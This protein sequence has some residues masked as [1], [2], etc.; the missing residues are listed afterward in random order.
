M[1]NADKVWTRVQIC[2]EQLTF[3]VFVQFLCWLKTYIPRRTIF[4]TICV[5]FEAEKTTKIQICAMN[6]NLITL[7]FVG[8]STRNSWYCGKPV[9]VLSERSN[10]PLKTDFAVLR[11]LF[12]NENIGFL[13]S[14][15]WAQ[16]L[17]QI[18]NLK[19]VLLIFGIGL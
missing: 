17:L 5:N 8:S 1:P 11:Q 12:T 18:R 9:R 4:R 13:C 19:K 7:C 10:T 3:P 16:L 15:K 6:S 2:E 14:K